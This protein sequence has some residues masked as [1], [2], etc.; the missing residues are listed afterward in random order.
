MWANDSVECIGK[1]ADL[2]RSKESYAR[3]VKKM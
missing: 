3:S 2:L 1:I